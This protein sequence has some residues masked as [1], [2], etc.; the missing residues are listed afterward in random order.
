MTM[1]LNNEKIEIEISFP[2]TTLFYFL[3]N[4]IKLLICSSNKISLNTHYSTS[5]CYTKK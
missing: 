2:V 3:K 5:N 1:F 4:A